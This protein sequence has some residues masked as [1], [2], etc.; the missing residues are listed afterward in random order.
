MATTDPLVTATIVEPKMMIE[1]MEL[2]GVKKARLPNLKL[3]PLAFMAGLYVGIGSTLYIILTSELHDPAS[4]FLAGVGFST[5]LVMI[6]FIG[7][8]LFT[9]NCMI[10]LSVLAHDV[11]VWEMAL[12]L[13]KVWVTNLLGCITFATLFLGMG[14]GGYDA[15]APAGSDR[16]LTSIGQRVCSMAATKAHLHP[17]ETFTRGILANMLVCLAVL[18]AQA[19]KS[20]AGKI[21]GIVIP[22][23]AF[24]VI[25]LEHSIANQYF[26]SLAT[27]YKCPTNHGL[28]WLN[29]L[30]CTLGNMAGAFLLSTVYFVVYL[31]HQKEEKKAIDA[32]AVSSQ[33]FDESTV[34]IPMGMALSDAPSSEKAVLTV[35]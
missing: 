27:L 6:L 16:A 7:A 14:I 24:C 17:W 22:I 4:R 13:A 28:Y 10:L 18:Q 33:P 5:G 26:L 35:S 20:P 15:M 31:S 11:R 3:F 29:L 25:G 30:L 2:L 23:C 19:A 1:T 12:D 32:K 9:G 34:S 21:L 8:E